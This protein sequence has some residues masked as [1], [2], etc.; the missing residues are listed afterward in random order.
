MPSRLLLSPFLHFHPGRVW[1]PLRETELREGDSDLPLLERLRRGE[2]G[3]DALDPTDRERLAG[4]GWLLPEDDP[5][6]RGEG[7]RLRAV[8]LETHTLCNQ[9]CFFCPV[10]TAPREPYFMPTPLFDR[11]VADLAGFRDTIECVFLINYNEPTIDRRFVDQVKALFAAGL[12]VGVLS[13]GTG[14]T[15]ARVDAILEAG[16]LRWLSINLSTIDP[17]RYREERRGDQLELVLRNLDYL[18]DKP[19]ALETDMAVLGLGDEKHRADHEAIRKRFEGS[20]FAVKPFEIMDRA[21]HLSFGAAVAEPHA[22][23]RGCENVGSRPL[24]HLHITPQGRCVFC[25]ED[26]EENYVVGDL[27]T[28]TVREVLLGPGLAR[29]RRWSYG[30]EEAPD[31]FIC[32]RCIFARTGEPER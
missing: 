27:T 22:S 7:A 2:P 3:V 4:G 25:C 10:S 12:P 13:N 29:L 20:R 16:T 23:L 21:G 8:S 15:P 31:D 6:L 1:N 9:A 5:A 14:L 28:S 19:L 17:V 11:I 32:R 18:K 26:Y 24:Q 30:L